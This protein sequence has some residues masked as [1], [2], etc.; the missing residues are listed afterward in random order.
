MAFAVEHSRFGLL[1]C[2]SEV[3]E[4]RSEQDSLRSAVSWI[5]SNPRSPHLSQEADVLLGNVLAG[6]DSCQGLG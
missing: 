6:V 2:F 1:G 3:T 5:I 4:P